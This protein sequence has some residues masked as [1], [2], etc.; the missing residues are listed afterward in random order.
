MDLKSTRAHGFCCQLLF[1]T[2]ALIFIPNT[3]SVQFERG[4]VQ[5]SFDSTWSIGGQWRVQSV[6]QDI[7]SQANGGR[8]GLSTIGN[9]PLTAN[10][11]DGSSNI[12]D[13][14][15][16]YST[17]VISST[18]KGIH[19]LSM[20]WGDYGFFVRGRYFYDFENK[21]NVRDRRVAASTAAS[22]VS[23]YNLLNVAS[24]SLGQTPATSQH[25]S[26]N[27][28]TGTPYKLSDEAQD[29]VGARAEFLDLFLSASWSIEDMPLD[30]RLGRQVISWGGIYIYPKRY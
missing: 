1:V 23:F 22:D 9:N 7:I 10:L 11:G 19:E 8:N 4:D 28:S 26:G 24:G 12:D 14:N 17:G 29:A 5:G 13:G 20:N 6:D 27:L 21:D 25:A 15:L 18:F 30:L 16:N 2:A 3:Y